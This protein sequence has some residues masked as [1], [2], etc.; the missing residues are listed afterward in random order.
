[1]KSGVLASKLDE[2]GRPVTKDTVLKAIWELNDLAIQ[3]FG[4]DER[5][6]TLRASNPRQHPKWKWHV[7]VCANS[8]LSMEAVGQSVKAFVIDR[9]ETEEMHRGQVD[10]LQGV[11][12]S[13]MN[14]DEWAQGLNKN[15]RNK[16]RDL[17]VLRDN[18][19]LVLKQLEDKK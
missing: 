6:V 13:Y 11:I 19:Q 9:R 7:P 1:M 10:F 2:Y 17:Q 4:R 18:A 5:V 3:R 12:A 15:S 8:E 16:V 14:L